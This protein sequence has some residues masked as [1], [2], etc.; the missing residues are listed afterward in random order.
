M[1]QPMFR[2]W[3]KRFHRWVAPQMTATRGPDLITAVLEKE[4]CVIVLASGSKDKDGEAIFFGDLLR[5]TDGSLMEAKYGGYFAEETCG[6]GLHF[7]AGDGQFAS[8]ADPFGTER[9]LQIEGNRY[10]NP[11]LLEPA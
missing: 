7:D 11:E 3:N 4:D 10:E 1:E 9:H 5:G 6:W 8:V 2:V